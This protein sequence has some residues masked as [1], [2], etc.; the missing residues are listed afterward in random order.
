MIYGKRKKLVHHKVNYIF[1][2]ILV[3]LIAKQKK[4]ME[5]PRFP[6]VFCTYTKEL[7]KILQYDNIKIWH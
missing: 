1:P 4:I 3:S 7:E 5:I 6:T 2:K